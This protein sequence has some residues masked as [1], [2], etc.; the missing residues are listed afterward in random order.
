M[1]T[2]TTDDRIEATKPRKLPK[3]GSIWASTDSVKFRVIDVVY[4]DDHVWVY[5]I[6]V[7][8]GTEYSCYV[9]SF[10]ARFRELPD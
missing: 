5:Y 4:T 9:D 7:K 8:D 2:F 3:P 1:T 10:L 6:K